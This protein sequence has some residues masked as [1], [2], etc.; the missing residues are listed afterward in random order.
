MSV[1]LWN[2]IFNLHHALLGILRLCEDPE[3]VHEEKSLT[4]VFVTGR[5]VECVSLASM[6]MFIEEQGLHGYALRVRG[7]HLA[8]VMRQNDRAVAKLGVWAMNLCVSLRAWDLAVPAAE[9]DALLRGKRI[10]GSAAD[11]TRYRSAAIDHL[12]REQRWLPAAGRRLASAAALTELCS[13]W[14]RREVAAVGTPVVDDFCHVIRFAT[15][16][17]EAEPLRAISPRRA[18]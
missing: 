10:C 6:V 5:L 13:G 1:T 14:T 3:V 16:L 2:R 18:A 8:A 17:L 15:E 9:W 11:D 4:I 12:Q 7:A